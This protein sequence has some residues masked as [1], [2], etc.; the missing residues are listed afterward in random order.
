MSIETDTFPISSPSPRPFLV[1]E[2]WEGCKVRLLLPSCEKAGAQIQVRSSTSPHD[3]VTVDFT[4]SECAR[5]AEVFK[6]LSEQE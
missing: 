3:A 1:I 6:Y 2:D 5:L 4:Y